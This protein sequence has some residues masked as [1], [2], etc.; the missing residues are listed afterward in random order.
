MLELLFKGLL[1]WLFDML[2]N[3]TE[4]LANSLLTIFSMNLAYFEKAVPVTGEIF[5][6]I[7]CL[8][9]ALM[10]G[11]LTFQSAKAMLTG[12]GFEGEAPQ[13]LF[14][15]TFVMTFFLVFSRQ[16]CDI[17]LG[18][19]KSVIELLEVPEIV[20]VPKLSELTFHV[21]GDASW[22]LVI[23]VGVILVVQIVKLF[24]EIGE[25]Y[26]VLAV[27]TVLSPLAFA[28]GGSK[29]TADIFKGWARMFGSMCLMAALSVV[30]LKC[31]L[32][33]MSVV[34]SGVEVVPWT[35]FVVAIAKTGRKID[36]LILRIGLNPA[37]T[38]DPL[39]G[40]TRMPGML[41]YIVARNMVQNI[42]KSAEAEAEQNG[43][44]GFRRSGGAGASY[45]SPA[46][47]GPVS[48]GGAAVV[49]SS[50]EFAAET[51]AGRSTAQS[52][53][54]QAGG[55]NTASRGQSVS[56]PP[57]G[58]AGRVTENT[59]P[60][61]M[62][63]PAMPRADAGQTVSADGTQSRKPAQPAAQ[64]GGRDA[65]STE[66]RRASSPSAARPTAQARTAQTAGMVHS[67][68]QTVAGRNTHSNGTASGK[69]PSAENRGT[70]YPGRHTADNTRSRS[71]PAD[72]GR[73]A[74]APASQTVQGT[75]TAHSESVSARQSQTSGRP[76]RQNGAPSMGT[77]QPDPKG[78]SHTHPPAH[79]GGTLRQ[80]G[81]TE[82]RKSRPAAMRHN[83]QRQEIFQAQERVL[84]QGTVKMTEETLQNQTRIQ[85][86]PPSGGARP[87][88][89]K[90]A[91][92]MSR[93][94]SGREPMRGAVVRKA[95]R[96]SAPRDALKPDYQGRE[97]PVSGK[98]NRKTEREQ[99]FPPS[100]AA[101]GR[102]TRHRQ[103]PTKAKHSPPRGRGGKTGDER[104]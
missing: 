92:G 69:P 102:H 41:T 95:V 78:A 43:Q 44:S 38:G 12:L 40:I 20:Q 97:N 101:Q 2:I 86:T 9:W 48:G 98:E 79:G 77:P 55:G 49:H 73:N 74:P 65:V 96:G 23:I 17:G 10:L 64:N 87:A 54:Q 83:G 62:G 88:A 34:P 33:A 4:Y 15:R 5:N 14:A 59:A 76:P 71:N 91:G 90:M 35:I 89:V 1:Q 27:L 51:A 32:S 42:G 7:T 67:T 26:V 50:E 45:A 93:P 70:P 39:G 103:K 28:M 63:N 16:V 81:T 66:A 25:R 3:I 85:T 24:F 80:N 53:P 52:N 72:I 19:T 8:G 56:R 60:Q 82:G 30:F 100:P 31:M 57:T 22:L 18:I 58:R 46:R 29:S 47:P 11:N 104:K 36:A 94:V 75:N 13:S 6:I 61:N 84:A 21:P 68:G 37:A 99:N